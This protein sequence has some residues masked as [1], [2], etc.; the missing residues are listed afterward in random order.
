MSVTSDNKTWFQRIEDMHPYETLLYLGMFGSGLIFLF[1]TVAFLF[2]GLDQLGGMNK[3]IPVSFLIST[4]LL[5]SSGYTATRIRIYFQEENAEKVIRALG[6]TLL[7]GLLFTGLQITGWKELQ[8]MGIDFQGI[9]SGSFLYV[10][11]GI[12]VFHLLGAMIF[13][14]ILWA[15]LRN[16]KNDEVKRLI[17][18]A[19]PFEKM[20]LRLFTVY[21]QFMDGIWLILFLLFAVS[22]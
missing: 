20:R 16:R 17:L 8:T 3:K 10:L 4:F 6:I 15:Q 11:S 18:F 13:A 21:W 19:N 12:H 2:S 7:L 5:V 1:L 9:P 14:V 22:L